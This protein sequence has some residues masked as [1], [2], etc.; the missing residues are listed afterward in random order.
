[1]QHCVERATERAGVRWGVSVLLRCQRQECRTLRRQGR[2]RG[3]S[4][5]L[6]R[7][8]GDL[9]VDPRPALGRRATRTGRRGSTGRTR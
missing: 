3:T 5:R 1:M 2:G 9:G 6:G 7:G 4:R 8:A